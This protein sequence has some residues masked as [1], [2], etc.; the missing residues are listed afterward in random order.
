MSLQLRILCIVGA[1]IT[2]VVITTNIRRKKMQ[3]EDSIFWIV[4]SAALVVVAFFP[5]I[6]IELSR[7][8]GFVAPSN[9]VFVVVIAILLVKLF[10]LSTDVSL[11]RH[12]LNELAQEEALLAKDQEDGAGVAKRKEANSQPSAPA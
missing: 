1:F 8:L 11:L 7:L 5:Q 9:F 4:L 6:A 3:I 10:Q 2:F 12:K